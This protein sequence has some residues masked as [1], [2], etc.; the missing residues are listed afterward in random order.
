MTGARIRLD[1][2]SQTPSVKKRR[3]P[4]YWVWRVENIFE[5]T[6]GIVLKDRRCAMRGLRLKPS[7]QQRLFGQDR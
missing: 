3:R 4:D 6:E 5:V 7:Q 1:T 2:L